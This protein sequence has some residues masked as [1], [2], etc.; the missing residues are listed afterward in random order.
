MNNT[1]FF[2]LMLCF[3]F[4]LQNTICVIQSVYEE[5]NRKIISFPNN[6]WTCQ[7]IQIPPN[8]VFHCNKGM[9]SIKLNQ[10]NHQCNV[11]N[12]KFQSL[13]PH[14]KVQLYIDVYGH[15]A[16]EQNQDDCIKIKM[17]NVLLKTE[18]LYPLQ[19]KAF[20]QSQQCSY[21]S[22][23]NYQLRRTKIIEYNNQDNLISL[24]VYSGTSNVFENEAYLF[25]NIQLFSYRCYKTCKTCFG[26]GK[27][28]CNSC[29]DGITKSSTN[30]CQSCKMMPNNNN[31]LQIAEGCKDKCEKN[32]GYDEDLICNEDINFQVSCEEGCQ[33]CTN[34]QSCLI[35]NTRKFLYFGQCLNSCPAYTKTEGMY[36]LNNLDIFIKYNLRIIQLVKE[37]HDLSTTKSMVNSLFQIQNN[38]NSNLNF[39]KGDGI[40][41]SYLSNKRIFGGP[42]VWVNAVF[43]F[44]IIWT[45]NIQYIK[46]FFQVILGDTQTN[47]NVFYYK[48]NNQVQQSITLNNGYVGDDQIIEDQNWKNSYIF[49]IYQVQQS[50]NYQFSSAKQ[51]IIDFDCKNEEKLAF[52]GIQNF[53]V[54]GFSECKSGY[55][56]DLF[57]YE[58]DRNPCIPICGDKLIVGEEECDD[59]NYDPFDGCFNC[60]YQCEEQCINCIKGQ[61]F[62]TYQ[63]EKTLEITHI[64][65][66]EYQLSYDLDMLQLSCIFNCSNCVRNICLRCNYGY[67]LNSINNQCVTNCGD[68]IQQDHEQCDDGNLDNYDGCSNCE[69]IQYEKCNQD[70]DTK[71]HGCS[72][73]YYGKCIKCYDGFLLDG[74]AC[75]SICGD[76]LLNKLQE[77]C[78]TLDEGCQKCKIKNGYVCGILPYSNCFTCDENCTE[79]LTLDKNNLICKSCING[80]YPIEDKCYMCDLNCVTCNLQSNLCTSC[81]REDCDFCESTPGLI[82]NFKTKKCDSI[83]GDGI[84]V[85]Y[86]EQCDD[87]NLK[88]GDG[89]DSQCNLEYS[90]ND[91]NQMIDHNFQGNNIY[92]LTINPSSQLYLLCNTTNITIENINNSFYLFT[93]NQIDKLTCRLQFDLKKTINKVNTIHV[94]INYAFSS[95]KNRLLLQK[96]KQIQYVITPK[97]FI[98]LSEDENIQSQTILNVQS[99]FNFIFLILIPISI[100]LNMFDS[101][102]VILEILSWINNFYFFNVNFPFNVETFFLN[103]DWSSYISL[104][105]YQGLNQPDSS[106]YFK[107][108]KRFTDKGIDPLFFN[109]IQTPFI[110]ILF[111]LI[112]YLINQGLYYIFSFLNTTLKPKI[113]QKNKAFTIIN[114]QIRKMTQENKSI[115]INEQQKLENP[116][117]IK[118]TNTFKLTSIHLLNQFKQTIQLCL[119]DITL[120][121]SLQLQ[122]S[123]DSSNIIVGL[124]QFFAILTIA[125]LIFQIYQQ[126]QILNIHQLKAKCKHFQELYGIYYEEINTKSSYGYYYQFFGQIRKVLYILF[127]VNCYYKPLLQ[128]SLCYLST[129]L[130]L[131]FLL[132]E[133]P[134]HSKKEFLIEFISNFCLS[135]IILIITLFAI[136]DQITILFIEQNKI[137]LGWLIISLVFLAIFFQICDILFR[138]IMQIAKII[139]IIIIKKQQQQQQLQKQ[140]EQQQKTKTQQQYRSETVFQVQ[141]IRNQ[142]QTLQIALF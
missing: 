136:N 62:L 131:F 3:S 126:Y 125:I 69:L 141:P 127:L 20:G 12:T 21:D 51:L 102:W 139:K 101:L 50:I 88:D 76:N 128:V 38:R 57:N 85:D 120:A 77:E 137:I 54:F 41:F 98:V 106:Y 2:H 22:S 91:L 86:Y 19:S 133:N 103:S 66:V 114:F 111:S 73:C 87:H 34:T 4:L 130:G 109:N 23:I 123:K 24:E 113:P 74:D 95:Q 72:V 14:F 48:I 31:F 97:E 53:V 92:D 116:Y 135:S 15:G 46:I 45:Q 17:N 96:D 64:I 100:I 33:L 26:E 115:Q 10:T 32:L 99:S 80:Y 104:P 60:R 138:L 110:F 105:T 1:P 28:E 13:L 122:F 117:L 16:L 61:C 42:F 132:F 79:C 36:C 68:S 89:C 8:Q 52:C 142:N 134:Y 78:D 37:F 39:L 49:N 83:C 94:K 108:P 84:Q 129:S 7:N 75:V 140:L 121:I 93:S 81:F 58:S 18:C 59:G 70:L 29:Y 9:D 90:D 71:K 30:S 47:R 118:I 67:Y 35:C 5:F 11:I 40:Y 82:P 44:S 55:T 63:K 107:A 119:L 124:N 27:N 6:K 43:Q 56:F 112:I 65:N 25:R